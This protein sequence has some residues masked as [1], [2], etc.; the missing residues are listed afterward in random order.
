MR[1]DAGCRARHERFTWPFTRPITAAGYRATH[2][3]L[4][5]ALSAVDAQT[6]QYAAELAL[7]L[8]AVDMFAAGLRLVP[9]GVVVADDLGLP[10]RGSVKSALYASTPPPVA[11]GF[12]QLA[13][14]R[15]AQRLSIVTRKLFPPPTF[16]RHW[17]PPAKRGPLM[18]AV[19]YLYRPLWL[20]GKAP[21]GWRAWRQA[22]VRFSSVAAK[23]AAS[24]RA[25]RDL[26]PVGSA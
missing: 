10:T 12:D 3:H 7:K 17:W 4:E 24:G 16:V 26:Q 18:L 6:W 8:D 15:G 20:A 25:R 22:R 11:L 2:R 23:P 14:A 13:T 21:A 5:A 19:G 9:A 1:A